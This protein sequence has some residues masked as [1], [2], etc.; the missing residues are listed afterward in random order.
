MTFNGEII[1][2]FNDAIS[3]A[4]IA[5]VGHTHPVIH[6]FANWGINYNLPNTFIRQMAILSI[7][8]NHMG[9]KCIPRTYEFLRKIGITK[10][11]TF[12]VTQLVQHQG[13][14]TVPPHSHLQHLQKYSKF[15]TFVINVRG[16]FLRVIHEPRGHNLGYF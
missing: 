15:L 12:D 8:Y 4:F 14:H 3:L 10:Y 1:E 16:Y 13:P 11:T 2:D 5:L 9:M 7:T 6:S